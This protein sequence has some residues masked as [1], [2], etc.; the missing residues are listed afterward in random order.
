MGTLP[1]LLSP[2]NGHFTCPILPV[3]LSAHFAGDTHTWQGTIARIEGEIDPM[4]RMVTLVCSVEDP[5]N[6]NIRAQKAP[7]AV[8]MFVDAEI[9]GKVVANAAVIERSAIRDSERVLVIDSENRLRY[10]KVN[11]VKTNARTLIVSKGLDQGDRV[12]ISPCNRELSSR[13]RKAGYSGDVEQ[14]AGYQYS[15]IRGY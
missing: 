11:V 6:I 4:T 14:A 13:N 15:N 9:A 8:G 3:T 12:C 5:Y 2:L 7:L 1:A 10:R